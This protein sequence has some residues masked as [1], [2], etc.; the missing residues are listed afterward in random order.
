MFLAVMMSPLGES[1]KEVVEALCPWT[2]AFSCSHRCCC[3]LKMEYSCYLMKYKSPPPSPWY[4][5]S[6]Q[7][8]NKVQHKWNILFRVNT[9]Y[10]E[11]YIMPQKCLGHMATNFLV[12]GCMS[13]KP[14]PYCTIKPVSPVSGMGSTCPHYT[15]FH[16][17]WFHLKPSE[18]R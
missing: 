10:T 1:N 9:L 16:L 2:L 17:I 14:C 6:I 18:G 12:S 4:L 13:P 7:F 8:L 15:Q 11:N 5:V 3:Q